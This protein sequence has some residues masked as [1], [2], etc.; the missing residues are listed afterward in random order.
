MRW[1]DYIILIYIIDSELIKLYPFIPVLCS[2]KYIRFEFMYSVKE[3]CKMND[4]MVKY[5]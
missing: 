5:K 2:K 1:G 3:T 4:W